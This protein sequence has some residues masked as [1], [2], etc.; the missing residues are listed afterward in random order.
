MR[1]SV[2]LR[3]GDAANTPFAGSGVPEGQGDWPLGGNTHLHCI[4][5][6]TTLGFRTAPVFW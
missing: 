2:L 6:F 3:T 5:L 4:R 1:A